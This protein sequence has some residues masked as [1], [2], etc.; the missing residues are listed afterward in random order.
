MT[1]EF[2]QWNETLES[3]PEFD[4]DKESSTANFTEIWQGE[5]SR[6]APDYIRWLQQSLNR[7][8][9]LRLAVDG[10]VGSQTRS[11]IRNFQQQ[12][13]LI[14]DGIVGSQTERALI[15]A[16]AAPPPGMPSAP[17]PTPLPSPSAFRPVP[18]ETPG[19][20]R[21]QDKTPPSASDLVTVTGVGGKPIQLHRL[22]AQAWQAL[23]AAARADGLREPLLLPGSGYRDPQLQKQLWDAALIKYGSAEEARKWVAPP[24][25]SAHQTGRAIDF[26]LGG[27]NSS[28]NVA[29]LRTL[30]AY[31]WMVANAARF[32]F[33]PYEREP[34][35]WEYNPPATRQF[36]A[37]PPSY[38][39]FEIQGEYEDEGAAIPAELT[40]QEWQGEVS[41]NSPE[42]IKW[43]QQSLNRIMNL[44]LAVDG[45]SGTQTRSA[46]RNFQ[47]QR[48]LEVDGIVGSQ[49][50]QA[51]IAAGADSP[52]GGT[53]PYV[54]PP[55]QPSTSTRTQLAQQVLN[56]PNISL[57]PYSPVS[58][59]TSDGADARSNISD[60]ASGQAA[61][62][63]S[64]GNAPGGSVYLD[65]RM[66]DGMLK[67]ASTYRI[68]V[69]SIAGGSHSATSR[70]YS[71][72]AFDVNEIN[73]VHVTSSNPYYRAVMQKCRDLGATEVLG[74]GASGH[75]T[76]VHC[77]WPR[78]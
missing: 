17:V 46:I 63:S 55:T 8:L 31:K 18:V 75:D 24:G 76:H 36:E 40:D 25:N 38:E 51:L 72:I 45:I 49:T 34:W 50:E 28:S 61:R 67:L 42:Y 58:S 32:G 29:Q 21:I 62:R 56:H 20:G 33:Y 47:Q 23:V 78:P 35:H 57:W 66:L 7:I 68:H 65:N 37:Y 1:S 27:H 10:I 41:R 15:A 77:A 22:A 3:Y 70:H 26:Y 48:G 30:P 54:P 6:G 71:G 16:G 44:R 60:T 12:K 74:P 39:V 19:G 14:V 11:A 52:P 9:G 64:Y 69:T 13:G 2:R 4:I 43:V 59:N 5:V 73:G 53:L